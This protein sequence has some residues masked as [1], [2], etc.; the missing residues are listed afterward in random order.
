MRGLVGALL[1]GAAASFELSTA[2]STAVHGGRQRTL[3]TPAR[4]SHSAMQERKKDYDWRV[5]LGLLVAPEAAL[6]ALDRAGVISMV[7]PADAAL[8]LALLGEAAA[9]PTDNQFAFAGYAWFGVSALAGVKGV[10]D[11]IAERRAEGS[12]ADDEDTL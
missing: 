12:G 1:L 8:P 7:P 6:W 11:K 5:I 10:A 2:V 4:S 9:A 3:P